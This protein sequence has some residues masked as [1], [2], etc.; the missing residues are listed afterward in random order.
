MGYKII[1]M[2]EKAPYYVTLAYDAEHA[3]SLK[4]LC[5][6]L[7]IK[8]KEFIPLAV[9]FFQK[10]G[11]DPRDRQDGILDD[12]RKITKESENRLIGFIKTQDKTNANEFNRIY[13]KTDTI[14]QL[15]SIT[16]NNLQKMIDI[17]QNTD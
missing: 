1:I 6:D 4:K 9:E 8:Q 11:I 14:H 2:E 10:T 5:R 13:E 3:K 16:S 7:D 12:F 17:L 15:A